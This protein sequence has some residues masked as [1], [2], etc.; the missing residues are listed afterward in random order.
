M[1]RCATAATVAMLAIAAAAAAGEPLRWERLFSADGAPTVHARVRY[2]DPAGK[3]HRLEIW[4]TARALR[5][6]TDDKLSLVVERRPGGDDQYHVVNRAGGR[7]YDVSR[8]QLYR[9]GSFPEWAQLATLLT[10][11]RGEVRVESGA[12]SRTAAG[13]CRWYEAATDQ[14]RERIC[15]SRALKLPLVVERQ[16]GGAWSPAVT[17]DEARSQPIAAAIFRV[18]TDTARVDV[19]HD[20]D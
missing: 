5:R 8:D 7:A 19:D 10:R 16:V 3:E 14:A 12:E 13:A 6:D 17:V 15:W 11:P 4:R 18:D 9:I 20:L 1:K 2:R